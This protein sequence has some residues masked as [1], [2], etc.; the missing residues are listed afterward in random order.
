MHRLVGFV[1]AMALSLGWPV[2]AAEPAKPLIDLTRLRSSITPGQVIGAIQGGLLCIRHGDLTWDPDGAM[3]TEAYRRLFREA[4]SQE[5]F[6][7]PDP[8]P[9]LF[10]S[11]T[12]NVDLQIGAVVKSVHSD[13]CSPNRFEDPQTVATMEVEW[14]LYSTIENKLLGRIQTQG[15]YSG[16][17]RGGVAAGLRNTF[18]A[19]ARE[20]AR[21]KELAKIVAAMATPTAAIAQTPAAPITLA[22][23]AAGNPVALRDAAKAV[24]SIFVGDSMG[25]GVLISPDGYLLTNH[26]VAGDE[27]RL[28]VRWPDGTDTVG[29]VVRADKRRDVALIKTTPPAG[30]SALAIRRTPMGLGETVFAIGTPLER[31]FA[32]TLTRGI[33]S[34]PSRTYQ[35]QLFIQSDVAVD[36]GNSG[37]PLLDEKGQIVG[38]TDL[39]YSPDGLSHNINLFIPIEEAL[40]V[41]AIQQAITTPAAA[42]PPRHHPAGHKAR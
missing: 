34:Q 38:L 24:V 9:D 22:M 3:G 27:G 4:M 17:S 39:R 32:G 1:V 18:A 20:F 23:L 14:Q 16:V 11:H 8:S 40:S 42:A 10:E 30:V 26:H 28:R 6:R 5:N 35:G 7:T 12:A 15:G 29:E 13:V 37:G 21:S 19:N 41:L 36:H 31:E 33:V 2:C 25:S